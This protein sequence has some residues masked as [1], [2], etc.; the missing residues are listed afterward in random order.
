MICATLRVHPISDGTRCESVGT[1]LGRIDGEGNG[2][3]DGYCVKDGAVAVGK[4]GVGE[5][6]ETLG[7]PYG[8]KV[9]RRVRY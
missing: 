7:G 5:S 1:R 4:Y 9:V 8:N 3:A 2:V 6:A